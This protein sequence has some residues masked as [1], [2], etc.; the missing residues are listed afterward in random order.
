LLDTY[1]K[2]CD[3]DNKKMQAFIKNLFTD[4]GKPLNMMGF[5]IYYEF[6]ESLISL[7]SQIPSEHCETKSQSDI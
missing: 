7:L 4:V 1:Y 5:E 6:K 3:G 2:R